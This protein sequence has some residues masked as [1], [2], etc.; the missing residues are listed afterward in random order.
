MFHRHV[1]S[2]MSK[3]CHLTSQFQTKKRQKPCSAGISFRSAWEPS[4]FVT[5]DWQATQPAA[6]IQKGL[7]PKSWLEFLSRFWPLVCGLGLALFVGRF[8]QSIIFLHSSFQTGK[9]FLNSDWQV[10]DYVSCLIQ[11]PNFTVVNVMCASFSI[12]LGQVQEIMMVADE[13]ERTSVR[14]TPDVSKSYGVFAQQLLEILPRPTR[15]KDSI[16]TLWCHVWQRLGCRL[17]GL[18][19]QKR[20]VGKVGK[21]IFGMS[22]SGSHFYQLSFWLSIVCF[23]CK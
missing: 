13:P 7:S 15:P 23:T 12:F 4:W 3:F 9:I 10:I 6:V 14:A 5:G 22:K 1:T 16:P 2:L 21:R 8:W 11:V 20:H 19:A 17:R 18:G